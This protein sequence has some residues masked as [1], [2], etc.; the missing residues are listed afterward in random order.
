MLRVPI[1]KSTFTLFT[2]NLNWPYTR[3]SLLSSVIQCVC[4]WG[5]GDA[6]AC[7]HTCVYAVYIIVVMISQYYK[8]VYR[9][10]DQLLVQVYDAEFRLRHCPMSTGIKVS[11]EIEKHTPTI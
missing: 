6:C 5:G 4:V 11:V 7:V 10:C 1:V 3:I 8:N 9:F 2:E